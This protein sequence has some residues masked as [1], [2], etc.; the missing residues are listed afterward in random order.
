VKME[1]ILHGTVW[2]TI[3][4]V[5][6]AVT[7]VAVS[8][9]TADWLSAYVGVGLPLFLINPGQ[10]A[11]MKYFHFAVCY[12]DN[13]QCVVLCPVNHS[14][15]Q[16]VTPGFDHQHFEIVLSSPHYRNIKKA[17]WFKA[18][19]EQN[20]LFPPN[21]S[22]EWKEWGSCAGRITRGLVRTLWLNEVTGGGYIIRT[23][24]PVSKTRRPPTYF[25][26]PDNT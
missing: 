13:G 19:N 9:A 26:P 7:T 12:G 20:D 14:D 6:M 25:F 5:A 22:R 3:M 15:N 4:T 2:V 16:H 10:V 21:R 8:V 17:F 23:L 11:Y 24:F 18:L 1:A